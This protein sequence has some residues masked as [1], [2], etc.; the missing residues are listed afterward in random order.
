[1]AVLCDWEIQA[2]CRG[3]MVENYDPDLIN[4]ASLDLR[5]GNGIMI[6]S[7]YSPELI[8]I[9]IS[10][11]TEDDPFMVQPGDFLL[12]ET[13]EVFNLPDD[14]SAQFVLKSSRARAGFNHMLAGWCDPGWH[15]STLTLEL[16]NER[17]HHPLAIFPGMKIGQMVFHS[18][19][20]SPVANYA[21]T[22]HYNNHLT[23]MPSV[24]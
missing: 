24:A 16:K 9:D 22:G 4:P 10:E 8:R 7:I 17:Q 6:E 1:M 3:G 5:L 19:S 11:K 18:M 21:K 20:S 2:R 14:I 23:V 12:A 13:I 15:G